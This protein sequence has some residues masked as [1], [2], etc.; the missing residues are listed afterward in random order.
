MKVLDEVFTEASIPYWICGG[1]LLGALRHQGFIPHDDDADIE[2]FEDDVPAAQ[3]ALK[4]SFKHFSCNLW[5]LRTFASVRNIQ[6]WQ[7][8]PLFVATSEE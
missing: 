2:M 4:V 3:D 5:L 7:Y 8:H 6:C 1:T